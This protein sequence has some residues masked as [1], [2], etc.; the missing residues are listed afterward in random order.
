MVGGHRISAPWIVKTGKSKLSEQP[1]NTSHDVGVNVVR[2]C[3][4]VCRYQGRREETNMVIVNIK[5]LSGYILDKSSLKLVSP[6]T[7]ACSFTTRHPHSLN[8]CLYASVLK[9]VCVC[10]VAAEERPLGEA[11]G[12]GGRIHQHLLRRGMFSNFSDVS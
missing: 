8:V 6:S 10:A 2:V 7:A 5:L 1:I 11:R 4:C 3:V 12:R 9:G